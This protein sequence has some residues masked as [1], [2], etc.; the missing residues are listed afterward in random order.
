MLSRF[1]FQDYKEE[2]SGFMELDITVAVKLTNAWNLTLVSQISTNVLLYLEEWGIPAGEMWSLE[3]GGM[4]RLL[5]CHRGC[6]PM[7]TSL[8]LTSDIS[9][10]PTRPA[11]IVLWGTFIHPAQE[12][13]MKRTGTGREAQKL[14]LDVLGFCSGTRCWIKEWV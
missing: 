1:I 6:V 8:L 7:A 10:I 9:C 12:R 4:Y 14:G 2:T 13:G 11:S 5:W 3:M